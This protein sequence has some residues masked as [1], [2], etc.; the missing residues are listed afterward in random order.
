MIKILMCSVV[1]AAAG[2]A[3]L[4]TDPAGDLELVDTLQS[5]V[6]DSD[7]AEPPAP[8]ASALGF[9]TISTPGGRVDGNSAVGVVWGTVYDT[10][11]DGHCAYAQ[12]ENNT[13]IITVAK[14]CGSPVSFN[15][16][17]WWRNARVCRT[18]TWTCSAWRWIQQ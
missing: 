16:G 3:E 17:G 15:Q 12:L 4:D 2:C 7:A 9:F 8:V 6:D 13:G 14:S 18:G 10:L 1:V 5:P 11:S